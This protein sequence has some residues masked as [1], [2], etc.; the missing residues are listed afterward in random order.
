M[1]A[2]PELHCFKADKN[3]S[4][5]SEKNRGKLK[6]LRRKHDS[7]SGKPMLPEKLNLFCLLMK[8]LT[9]DLIRVYNY[10]PMEISCSE[11]LL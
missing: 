8:R 4:D 9:S 10:L 11:G 5:F 6:K 7:G 2:A 1:T 3:T